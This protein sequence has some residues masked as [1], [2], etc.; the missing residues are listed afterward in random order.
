MATYN[1]GD[2]VV[3]RSDLQGDVRYYSHD[4]ITSNNTTPEMRKLCGKLVH[5][6]YVASDGQYRITEDSGG[7][8]WTDGMFEDCIPVAD[9]DIDSRINNEG[10]PVK[11]TTKELSDLYK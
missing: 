9:N 7:F 3:V 8:Y 4:R 6:A 1:V 10:F 5:I 2:I 11:I